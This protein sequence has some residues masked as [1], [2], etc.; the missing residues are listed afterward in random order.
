LL[1]ATV[2]IAGKASQWLRPTPLPFRRFAW[3]IVRYP[4][5]KQVQWTATAGIILVA[6]G[7]A[8][9][10]TLRILEGWLAVVSVVSSIAVAH[11]YH[12]RSMR[13]RMLISVG[14]LAVIEGV[15]DQLA[16][17][18]ALLFAGW[19]LHRAARR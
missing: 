6:M 15:K 3:A 1:R 18:C 2:H 4:L 19:Q 5:I 13:L 7:A 10:P 8:V 17:P 16:L 12:T 11:A 14:I 9:T